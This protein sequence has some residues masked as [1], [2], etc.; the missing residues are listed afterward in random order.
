MEKIRAA[1]EEDVP[2]ILALIQEYFSYTQMDEKELSRRINSPTFFYHTAR[3]K[4]A[5]AGYAEWEIIDEEKKIIRLNGIAVL[6][7]F[8][9]RGWAHALIQAGE[10]TAREKGM[11]KMMLLVAEKNH[12]AKEL[13]ARNEWVFAR[14][15]LRKIN[16]ENTEVWEKKL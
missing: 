13:Y 10:K 1:Q 7:E 16:G 14:K 9:G 3:E 8:Q 4:N 11:K 5:F 15:H 6:S 12:S 2:E